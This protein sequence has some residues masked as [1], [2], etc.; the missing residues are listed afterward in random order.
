MEK[1]KTNKKKKA[2]KKLS[3]TLEGIGDNLNMQQEMFCRLYT[4]EKDFFGNGI[5]AYAE[6]YDVNTFKP[7]WRDW[8]KVNVHRLL[9]NANILKRINVLLQEMGFN[10]AFIDKELAFLITQKAD[11]T[12]KL[13][14]IREYNKLKKRINDNL[15]NI[16]LPIPIYANRSTKKNK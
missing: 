16:I 3:E 5:D 6:A 7:K 14:G 4:T 2:N 10:D 1:K 13:G 8:V 9:T 11:L 12:V 15:V